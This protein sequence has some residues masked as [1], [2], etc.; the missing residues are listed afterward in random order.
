MRARS[1]PESSCWRSRS[2]PDAYG[3][4]FQR[5]QFL[6]RFSHT[7]VSPRESPMTAARVLAR[8]AAVLLAAIALLSNSPPA[9]AQG[10]ATP[11][12]GEPIDISKAAP[13]ELVGRVVDG[14]GRPMEG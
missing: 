3:V 10:P 14:E 4:V 5:K 8:S 11:K 7:S 6:P 2:A 1:P 9:H 13:D 12:A